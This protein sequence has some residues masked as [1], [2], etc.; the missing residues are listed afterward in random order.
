MPNKT[1]S[2]A[3]EEVVD[4][5]FGFWR[6]LHRISSIL[7]GILAVVHASVTGLLYSAWDADSVWFLG[8]G[9]G[10]LLLAV[11]N[12][13]HI[14]LEPCRQPTAPAIRWANWVFLLFSGSAL[15]AVPEP[16]AFIIVLGLLGQ[17]VAGQKTLYGPA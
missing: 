11:M 4:S 16:Q 5:R 15:L 1:E 13:T 8:T 6:K 9:L 12:Y 2:L 10:L 7:L 14:G 17:A 3:H